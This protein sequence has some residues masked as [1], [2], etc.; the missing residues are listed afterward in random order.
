MLDYLKQ[1]ANVTTTENGAITYATTGSDCLDLFATIGA[2]RSASETEIISRF[3]RAYT[4]N[5]D[6]A[7]KLFAQ[8]N[9]QFAQFL[10]DNQGKS[11][12]QIA[13]DY[14]LDWNIVQNFLK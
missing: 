7:M 1:E 14:G 4:E 11:P 6:T 2:L 13:Q 10:R 9:P 3:L 8:K 5:P 12:Q